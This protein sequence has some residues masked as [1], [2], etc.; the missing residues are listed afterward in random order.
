MSQQQGPAEGGGVADMG[1]MV[2]RPTVIEMREGECSAGQ[3]KSLTPCVYGLTA[4]HANSV[5]RHASFDI[6]EQA[7]AQT[8]AAA[9]WLAAILRSAARGQWV[10][11]QETQGLAVAIVS[12]AILVLHTPVP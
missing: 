3:S 10:V 8:K 7:V 5:R 11:P 4:L 12:E 9:V 2:T 6:S 1:H